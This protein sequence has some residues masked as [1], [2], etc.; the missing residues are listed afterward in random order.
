[1]NKNRLIILPALFAVF[2]LIVVS[3]SVSVNAQSQEREID[4]Q[5][6]DGMVMVYR[7]ISSSFVCV[8]DDTAE[9]W[10][11]LGLAVSIS[12]PE[13][14]PAEEATRTED[15]DKETEKTP[16]EKETEMKDQD[17]EMEMK[18][19]K[20]DMDGMMM[21]KPDTFLKLGRASVP[22]TIPLHMGWYNGN[23][24]YYI[25]TDSSDK[26]HADVITEA[27][28]WK[29]ELAPPLASTPKEALSKTYF[30]TNGIM[31]HGVHGFQEQVFSSTPAQP[32][33][34]SALT[35]HI[36]VTWNDG[37]A[38]ERLDSEAK[39][40][41]AERDGKITLTE[42][43]VVINMPQVV[44]PDGQL[45]VRADKT[46][47]DESEYG[48]AQIL[49]INTDEM[50]VTFVAHRGWGPDGRTIYYIV[51]DATPEMPA[52]MMGVASSPTS[53]KLI[54][55]SAAVDLF[56][57]MNGIGGAGPMGFQPGIAAGA[58]GDENYSPMWR[59]FM[60]G[61][62]DPASASVLETMDD[63]NAYKKAGLIDVELARPM[64]SDHI[65]NCPFIDPFQ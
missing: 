12:Q 48:E 36:H 5:C 2:S 49:D 27:Q 15:V 46:L 37:V 8:N 56:Q 47:T 17:K 3:G 26:T 34:Y 44:W 7:G 43:P 19:S 59:I 11:Q 38:A 39:I 23:P 18:D 58:L 24:V 29:V 50:T 31:G 20:K 40:L 28:G 21:E 10:I 30:F 22:A 64:N 1:M 51:T 54:A 14:E 25:I 57:F 65:V 55:S 33:K 60:I 32:E 35:S 42:L 4:F 13:E 52:M 16:M 45:P 6:R 63:I 53:A 61:W 41:N 9:R 62:K